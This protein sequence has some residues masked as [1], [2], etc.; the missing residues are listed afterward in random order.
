M[1]SFFFE[2]HLVVGE[3]IAEQRKRL[4]EGAAADRDLCAAVRSG[5]EGREALEHAESDRR[6]TIRSQRSQ[7]RCAW[8]VR[9]WR[10][11]PRPASTPQSLPD[12]AHPRES[13]DADLVGQHAFLDHVA[14]DL[15][16]RQRCSV[17]PVGHI[18]ECI[19]AKFDR[20]HAN[21]SRVDVGV[22]SP[23][24]IWGFTAATSSL[25][26]SDQLLLQRVGH[27]FQSGEDWPAWA[28]NEARS[29]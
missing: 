11:T 17:R 27:R 24:V 21:V 18:A 25:G 5:I 29:L 10:P 6:T 9:R 8:Y 28:F 14:D 20:C 15:C 19:E 16:L 4:D 3:L 2:Q 1:S 7:A 22:Q 23:S 26:Q 12:D 13:I